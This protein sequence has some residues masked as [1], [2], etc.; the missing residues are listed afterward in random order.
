IDQNGEDFLGDEPDW[1]LDLSKEFGIVWHWGRKRKSWDWPFHTVLLAWEY[2]SLTGSWVNMDDRPTDPENWDRRP[3]AKRESYPFR[4][5][6]RSGRVQERSATIIQERWTRG[7]HILSR[8]G[9]PPR[10]KYAIDVEFD[11][12]VGEREG[13]WKGGTIGCGYDMLPGET[14]LQALRRME[15]ERTFS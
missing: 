5:T 9:W 13:S 8:L 11:G 4:Y 12:E 2:E 1:G 14:P 10:V 7:R 15:R 6:L 3:G